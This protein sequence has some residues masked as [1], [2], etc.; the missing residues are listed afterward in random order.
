MSLFFRDFS[1]EAV[2]A[3]ATNFGTPWTAPTNYDI[4]D[5]GGTNRL[6]LNTT[7]LNALVT[8]NGFTSGLDGHEVCASWHVTG[9]ISTPDFGLVLGASGNASSRYAVFLRFDN[10]ALT[11][12]RYAGGSPAT[13][14]AE[15]AVPTITAGATY[16]LRLR[17]ESGTAYGKMWAD[18]ESEPET[19]TIERAC[20][21]IP[22]G[23][24]GILVPTSYVPSYW[25][26]VGFADAGEVAPT[27]VSASPV[28]SFL[29]N[30]PAY[31]LVDG[32]TIS[33][34]DASSGGT[35]P[36][37]YSWEYSTDSGS[38]W[39]EFSTV[40]NPV[41]TIP[42]PGT[43][44]V[45]LTITDSLS[46]V[47][48]SSVQTYT[49]DDSSHTYIREPAD[50]GQI[51]VAGTVITGAS[52]STP[53]IALAPR[54]SLISSVNYFR[55]F[56]CVVYNCAGKTPAFTI[57]WATYDGGGLGAFGYSP[58]EAI[59]ALGYS[60]VWT[61]NPMDA[62]SWQEFPTVVGNDTSKTISATGVTFATGEDTVYVAF[63]PLMTYGLDKARVEA[64]ASNP[65][66]SAP[67]SVVDHATK[68]FVFATLPALPGYG[69]PSL[70]QRCFSI[71]SGPTVV[72]ITNGQ[73]SNEDTGCHTFWAFIDFLLS[74]A[75]EA[76]S[77]RAN[78]TINCYT[79]VN[80]QG[81]YGGIF[82]GA[83]GEGGTIDPNRAW[84]GSTVQAVSNV[85]AAISTDCGVPT[86][87]GD[88]HGYSGSGAGVYANESTN[89]NGT[90]DTSNDDFVA[91]IDPLASFTFIEGTGPSPV[92]DIS[93]N[94]YQIVVGSK[95]AF[96]IETGV[97][98]NTIEYN[99]PYGIAAAKA[100]DA[101]YQSN[102]A[103]PVVTIDMDFATS[104]PAKLQG[105]LLTSKV[106]S[107]NQELKDIL[108]D[109]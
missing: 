6:Y 56:N 57:D 21:A 91:A 31:S 93:R 25:H 100:L 83:P 54:N 108:D 30:S 88:F 105:F 26:T 33:F 12:R 79:M 14:G 27:E 48:V 2:A 60:P 23:Y 9:S 64:L 69:I 109:A 85:K 97:W 16:W 63:Q 19:W 61:T 46:A 58:P 76:V 87:Y 99:E 4:V 13:L 32:E 65:L 50:R 72:A 37:T 81:F 51:D 84:N 15:V 77:A 36:Y 106:S 38:N 3:P 103:I 82:R 11:I 89:V 43:L 74:D 29:D 28:A 70:D 107:T 96:N 5:D 71:G 44:Q 68:P 18:G 80:P 102:F 34:T 104:A 55:Y 101:V 45:R 42:S 47:G 41:F 52:G 8:F 92:L 94:Y 22:D 73:H 40:A 59:V 66:V 17:Y 49:I 39:S 53:A 1:T 24:P 10:G 98:H 78:Y 90:F 75:A 35:A 7:L 20:T 95:L 86:V 67:D 62:N